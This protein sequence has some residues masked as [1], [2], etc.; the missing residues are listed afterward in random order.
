VANELYREVID[1]AVGAFHL[2]RLDND[3][4]HSEQG[5]LGI[6]APLAAPCGLRIA[7]DLPL[8]PYLTGSQSQRY[9]TKGRAS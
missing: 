6:P 4:Q 7:L 3:E 5:P 2:L 1:E 9:Q 8:E